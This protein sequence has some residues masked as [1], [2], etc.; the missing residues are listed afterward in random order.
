M[1][2][3]SRAFSVSILLA[4][5][6]LAYP[7]SSA[8]QIF[9]SIELDCLESEVEFDLPDS[10]V[11]TVQCSVENP[12]TYSEKVELDYDSA[13]I[14]VSGP[15]S[16]SVE[17]GG[18]ESF[19]VS[20]RAGNS[21]YYG[22]HEV[23]V[24]AH[25][26]EAGGVPVGIITDSE[27]V[28]ITALVPEWIS[29]DANYGIGT[30]TVEAGQD[31]AF[32]ASYSCEG[33]K[34]QSLDVELHLVSEGASQESMWPSGF[35]DISSQDCSVEISGGDGVVNCQFIVTTPPNLEDSWSGCIVL[36][37]ERS[38]SSL[39]CEVEDSLEFV[40]NSKESGIGDIGIGGN[41]SIFEDLGVSEESGLYLI[42]AGVVV[43]CAIGLGFY[44]RRRG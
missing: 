21:V 3:G 5:S 18:K 1:G 42:G 37:D 26:T 30:L 12:H 35:N 15:D 36:L 4:V 22:N 23:N 28:V 20:M 17:G 43:L 16:I 29:C 9:P 11:S 38:M 14:I 24:S 25:V 2:I 8:Q 19:E 27:E 33:N 10:E 31:A 44:F 39:S 13:D 40:V 6:L 32:S 34:N 7:I 41:G